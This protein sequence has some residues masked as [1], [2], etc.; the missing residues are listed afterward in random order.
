MGALMPGMFNIDPLAQPVVNTDYATSAVLTAT[1]PK[2][3]VTYKLNPKATWDDGTPITKTDFGRVYLEG[4]KPLRGKSPTDLPIEQP[5]KFELVL[6]LKAADKLGLT[7]S[8]QLLL[9]TDE[10][11]ESA[12]HES[13]PGTKLRRSTGLPTSKWP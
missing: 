5:S 8:P 2:Q 10:V 6:N 13:S 7:F 4:D 11:I 1:E 3:I 9:R 12:L